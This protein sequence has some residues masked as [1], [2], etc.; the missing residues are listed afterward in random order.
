MG[1]EREQRGTGDLIL[2]AV[3][4]ILALVGLIIPLW[5][6]LFGHPPWI[7]LELVGPF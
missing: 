7:V 4:A 6:L 3:A 2:V 5:A 1:E